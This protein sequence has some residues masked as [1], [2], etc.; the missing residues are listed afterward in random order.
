MPASQVALVIKNLLAS[1]GESVDV[2]SGP[3]LGTSLG[4]GN[5]KPLQSCC[6]ENAM[7][8]GVWQATVLGVTQSRT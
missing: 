6:L 3:E 4:L 1:T 5:G 8:R 7:D 2:G